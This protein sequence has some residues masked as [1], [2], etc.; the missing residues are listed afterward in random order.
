M[1]L[2]AALMKLKKVNWQTIKSDTCNNLLCLISQVS[3]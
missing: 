3:F 1:P 2:L